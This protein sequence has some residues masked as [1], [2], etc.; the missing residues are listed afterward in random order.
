MDGSTFWLNI[1]RMVIIGLVVIILGM[2]SCA[3][4]GNHKRAELM[5]QGY[6]ANA[7][8]CAIYMGDDKSGP[9]ACANV[10]SEE[11]EL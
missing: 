10:L 8:K 7:V 3:M 11:K 2:T 6:S 1:W 5:S 4:H 9:V